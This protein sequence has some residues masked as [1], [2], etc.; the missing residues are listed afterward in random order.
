[1]QNYFRFVTVNYGVTGMFTYKTPREMIEGYSDPIIEKLNATPV[2]QG[3]DQLTSPV[4]S[5]DN[6]PTHPV[7]NPISLFTGE[8]NYLN[9]RRYGAWLDQDIIKI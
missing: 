6:P 2:Y 5:L 1:M 9:T 7:D 8:G 3:G 4:L